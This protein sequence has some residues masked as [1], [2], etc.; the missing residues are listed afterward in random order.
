VLGRGFVTID[1]TTWGVTIAADTADLSQG[2][3][4]LTS[5]LP[6]TGELFDLG[7]SQTIRVTTVPMLFSLDI[8]F[9][10][11]ELVVTEVYRDIQP[12][13]L[14]TPTQQAR[15]F[16]EVNAGELANVDPGDQATFEI[17]TQPVI[18]T[19]SGSSG[20]LDM[21]N[22]LMPLILG[23]TFLGMLLP[24]IKELF[25]GKEGK[26]LFLPATRKQ[27]KDKFTLKAD[28]LGNIIITHSGQTGKDV[29]MQFESDKE[30]VYNILR[31]DERRDLDAGWTVDIQDTEPRASILQELWEVHNS[32]QPC[33]EK[34]GTESNPPQNGL[35]FLPDSQEFLAYTIEDIGYREKIDQAFLEAINRARRS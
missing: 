9:L 10:D 16:L 14:V 35:D 27:E 33:N 34:K 6:N 29:F 21:M 5:L 7:V 28:R 18:V 20:W 13:Y 25:E 22:A 23:I 8:A 17:T 4:G 3:G 11:E 12:G 26:Q 32:E 19:A 15:Y 1:N 30:L 24:V 2:L 31:K